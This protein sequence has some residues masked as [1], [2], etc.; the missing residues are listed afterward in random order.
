MQDTY[1]LV[2]IH[3]PTSGQDQ[4]PSVCQPNQQDRHS[5]KDTDNHVKI[6]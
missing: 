4:E 5:C 1:Q 3:F 2:T 6:I